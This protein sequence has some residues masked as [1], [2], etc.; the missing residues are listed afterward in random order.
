MNTTPASLH[1][2]IHFWIVERG[3]LIVPVSNR[4]IMPADV[5]DLSAIVSGDQ[6]RRARAARNCAAS[7]IAPPQI[8]IEGEVDA[9]GRIS[10]QAFRCICEGM[11]HGARFSF[12][13]SVLYRPIRP[14]EGNPARRLMGGLR[15]PS[16]PDIATDNRII[17]LDAIVT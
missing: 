13:P 14:T 15:I 16:T 8:E 7:I 5:P 10:P 12:R 3:V 17:H 11:P 9:T 2:D 6:F 1:A 4:S